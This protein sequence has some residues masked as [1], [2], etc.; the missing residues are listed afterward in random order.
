MPLLSDRILSLLRVGA[1][2]AGAIAFGGL[3]MLHPGVMMIGL[4]VAVLSGYLL[5]MQAS[6]RRASLRRA[7][8]GVCQRCGYEHKL[9]RATAAEPPARCPECGAPLA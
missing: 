7:E 6:V 4:I 1:L 9:T 5:V 8:E 3:V 2:C